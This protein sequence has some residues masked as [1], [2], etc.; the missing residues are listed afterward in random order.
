MF[1]IDFQYSWQ[2]LGNEYFSV[3][4]L[5]KC[6]KNSSTKSIIIFIQ[7]IISNEKFYKLTF[8]VHDKYKIN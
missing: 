1:E 6:Q 5:V 3:Q 7:I 4:V 8:S 2:L